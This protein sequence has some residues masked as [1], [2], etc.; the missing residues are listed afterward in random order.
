MR[1]RCSSTTLGCRVEGIV[2]VIGEVRVRIA[3]NHRQAFG[4]AGI[5]AL[6]GNLD[7]AP[8]DALAVA[9][10]RQQGAVAAADIEYAGARL[11][12][13]GHEKEIEAMTGLEVGGGK[14]GERHAIPRTRAAASMK[15]AAAANI[16]GSS[17]R[18]ASWPLSLSTS[19]KATEAAAA[20]RAWTMARESEVGN[21]QSEVNEI[22]QKRVVDPLKALASEPPCS[23][24]MSK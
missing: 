18:N 19:T 8:V 23:A 11:D 12:H 2:R 5:H 15:P 13:V 17:S 7:A 24:A 4:Q 6:A 21:S 9:Q 22:T 16:S 3:L 10:D 1:R 14:G 20:F